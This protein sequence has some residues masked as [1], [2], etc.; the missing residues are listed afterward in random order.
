MEDNKKFEAYKLVHQQNRLAA[1]S[2]KI[3][4]REINKNVRHIIRSDATAI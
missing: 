4:G 2:A 3:E 1:L